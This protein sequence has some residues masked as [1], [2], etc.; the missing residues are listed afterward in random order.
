MKR[1]ILPLALLGAL[2]FSASPLLAADDFYI[3]GGRVTPGVKITTL[4]YIIS[5]PGYYYLTRNLQYSGGDGITVTADNVTIDLMGFVLSGSGTAGFLGIKL[6]NQNNVEVR[7]GTITGWNVAMSGSGNFQRAIGVRAIDT[8]MGITLGSNSLIKNCSASQG[9]FGS[10][11]GLSVESGTITG[12]AVMNFTPG[13][14]T[15][16]IT[17]GA[18]GVASG[19]IVLNCTGT[20]IR[21]LSGATI[22]GNSI[23]N[24]TGGI[25][26]AGGGSVIGNA[27]AATHTGQ[28]DV[29]FGAGQPT[30]GDQNCFYYVIG[31]AYY[32]GT[33]VVNWSWAN[34]LGGP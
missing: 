1:Y 3:V 16:N 28:T 19:N 22:T 34:G 24:C 5:S 23:I 26:I 8:I 7:N 6:G 18:G 29:L 33:P 10:G 17:M 9:S 20:G 12:C 32:S 15:G 2:W 11:W 14:G 13:S 21:E 27:V 25:D 31:S 30:V 4:P